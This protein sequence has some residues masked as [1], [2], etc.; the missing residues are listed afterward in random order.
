MLCLCVDFGYMFI[1]GCLICLCLM[2]V[3]TLFV[4]M[5]AEYNRMFVGVFWISLV[6]FV[7]EG[8]GLKLGIAMK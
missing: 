2:F 4:V 3:F 8:G 6:S 7:D 5:N 1:F